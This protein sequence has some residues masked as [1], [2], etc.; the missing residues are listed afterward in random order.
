MTNYYFYVH[1]GLAISPSK[2]SIFYSLLMILN[3]LLKIFLYNKHFRHLPVLVT[4]CFMR[5]REFPITCFYILFKYYQTGK[6][7]GVVGYPI[8]DSQ[9]DIP[10]RKYRT[11]FPVK[12]F[13][14]YFFALLIYNRKL[15]ITTE[16]QIS[17]RII[18]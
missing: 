5:L 8:Q 2:E 12:I 3:I 11:I 14:C 9:H 17:S 4:Y 7:R 18:S 1:I 10:L 15:K 13:C 16:T 6:D